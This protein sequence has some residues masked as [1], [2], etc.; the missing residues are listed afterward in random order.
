MYQSHELGKIGE[1]LVEK[2]LKN[3]NYQVIERNFRCK[4]GEIDIIAKEKDELVFIEVKTRAS[5]EYGKPAEAVTNQK[6][7]HIYRSAEYYLAMH[8]KLSA[9]VR[10]DVVE[11]YL[12]KNK[13]YIHHIKS[14]M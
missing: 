3:I 9:Y 12:Y 13:Y 14:A 2:Y 7:K 6:K 1:N 5:M 10:I 8:H 11:V 4:R